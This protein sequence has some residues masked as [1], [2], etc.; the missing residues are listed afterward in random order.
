[1]SR[2]Y[3]ANVTRQ[4]QI[5][6]YRLDFTKEGE[7]QQNTQFRPHRQQNIPAGRQVQI[8]S[9][10]HSKQIADIV[11]QLAKFGLIGVVDI[12][13]I[14]GTCF[15]PYIYN[16]D[17]PVSVDAMRAVRDHNS[18]VK[19]REGTKRR[20]EAA[21]ATNAIVQDT[22]AQQ[23]AEKGIDASPSTSTDVVFEQQPA[24]G[25]EI[26]GKPISEGFRVRPDAGKGVRKSKRN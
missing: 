7:L 9:D 23:F 18:A 3:I 8:G 17:K 12:P 15:H 10:W 6:C 13:R 19:N 1:M 16:I 22:V 21:V 11:D 4:E 5:V 2:L 24:E 26:E 14:D 25:E 20:K